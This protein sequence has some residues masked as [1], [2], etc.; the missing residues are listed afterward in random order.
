MNGLLHLLASKSPCTAMGIGSKPIFVEASIQQLTRSRCCAGAA[1]AWGMLFRLDDRSV[2]SL[3]DAKLGCGSRKLRGLISASDR[4]V[5][6]FLAI[7]SL[8]NRSA[9]VW[10]A[11]AAPRAAGTKTWG[12]CARHEGHLSG[13]PF[14]VS[15][16]KAKHR[17]STAECHKMITAQA[18]HKAGPLGH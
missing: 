8:S 10:S 6:L 18:S 1:L 16:M 2:A 7:W 4:E 15:H 13:R 9:A 14:Q 11:S 3:S 17:G 12:L 5:L